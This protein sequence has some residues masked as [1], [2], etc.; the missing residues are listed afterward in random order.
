MIALHRQPVRRTLRP[1]ENMYRRPRGFDDPAEQFD[2]W[3][4]ACP[5]ADAPYPAASS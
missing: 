3:M 1:R 5:E 2:E 4:A